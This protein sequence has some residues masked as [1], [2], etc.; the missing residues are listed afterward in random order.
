MNEQKTI[1][2]CDKQPLFFS[3]NDIDEEAKGFIDFCERIL[4]QPLMLWK[5]IFLS[6]LYMNLKTGK[7]M[8]IFNYPR[9]QAKT[10]TD[11]LILG[12]VAYHVY[13]DEMEGKIDEK[14]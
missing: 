2:G 6:R 3:E 11:T 13:C 14:E 4:G 7:Q 8:Y 12:T 9:G 5:K 1:R 10:G